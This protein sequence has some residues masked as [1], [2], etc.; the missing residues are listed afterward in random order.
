MDVCEWMCVD[1]EWKE[2]FM[3]DQ[4]LGGGEGTDMKCTRRTGNTGNTGS[5]GGTRGTVSNDEDGG[6]YKVTTKRKAES[7][8]TALN[9]LLRPRETSRSPHTH[10]VTLQGG[11]ISNILVLVVLN[12]KRTAKSDPAISTRMVTVHSTLLPGI[13]S[14]K[15]TDVSVVVAQ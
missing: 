5:T 10:I 12:G 9:H 1:S 2:V 6:A 7:N 3:G 13:M 15:P 4:R 8:H 11:V 14:P